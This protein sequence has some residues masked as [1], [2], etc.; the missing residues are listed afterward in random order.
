[1]K[2]SRLNN[3]RMMMKGGY[4]AI[5]DAKVVDTVQRI[6]KGKLLPNLASVPDDFS[7]T[8]FFSRQYDYE[9]S[10]LDRITAKEIEIKD[11]SLFGVQLLLIPKEKILFTYEKTSEII[12]PSGRNVKFP[13]QMSN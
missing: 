12:K 13:G 10:D 4:W 11:A 5:Y 1:M 6:W 8:I 7:S 9:N 3:A 2:D